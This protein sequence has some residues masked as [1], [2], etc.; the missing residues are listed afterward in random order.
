MSADCIAHQVDGLEELLR[1]LLDLMELPSQIWKCKPSPTAE[2][3]S[4]GHL[5]DRPSGV[6]G[7]RLR[8]I[9]IDCI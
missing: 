5:P 6:N 4:R 7:D 8:L 9:A 1:A 3:L 2:E